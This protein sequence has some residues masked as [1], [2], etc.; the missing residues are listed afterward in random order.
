MDEETRFYDMKPIL[1][2]HITEKQKLINERDKLKIKLN[3]TIKGLNEIKDLVEDDYA[4][5]AAIHI[6]EKTLNEVNNG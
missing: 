2:Q 4:G 6:A 3:I 5:T 1:D